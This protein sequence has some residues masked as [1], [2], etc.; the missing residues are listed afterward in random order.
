MAYLVKIGAIH[1]NK[2]GV[3]SRGYHIYRRAQRIV[4]VWGRVEV[5]P[6]GK[7]FYWASTTQHKELSCRSVT[8]AIER[9]KTLVEQ[10]IQREQ[11][12]L[13][14]RGA[15]IHRSAASARSA[16]NPS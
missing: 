8:A 7:R 12:S 13:L 2:S 15:R 1:T 16:P 14:P 4:T 5:K 6:R 9:L 11:Y 10:R 3:G